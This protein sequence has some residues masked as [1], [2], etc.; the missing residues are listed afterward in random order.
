MTC[1]CALFV[2]VLLCHVVCVVVV[3]GRCF[4]FVWMYLDYVLLFWLVSLCVLHV[5]VRVVSVPLLRLSLCLMRS[6]VFCLCLIGLCGVLCCVCFVCVLCDLF[7]FVCCIVC[8]CVGCC[9]L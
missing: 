8:V 4:V 5:F 6:C 1:L 7:C 9:V 2:V 3:V